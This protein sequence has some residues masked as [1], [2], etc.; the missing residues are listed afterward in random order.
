VESAEPFPGGAV[1]APDLSEHLGR[2]Q[3]FVSVYLH[4]DPDVENAGQL[5]EQRWKTLRSELEAMDA[6]PETLDR[7]EEQVPDAHARGRVLGVVA[8][9]S[10]ALHVEHGE[11]FRS[12][13]LGRIDPV[14]YVL[15][16]IR[17][18][19]TSPPILVVLIDRTGADVFAITRGVEESR[20]VAGEDGPVSKVSAGG[21]SMR[22]Y[23]ER[24]ENTWERNAENVAETLQAMARRFDPRRIAV[25]GDVRAAT[26]LREALA[27]E[28]Q[29]VVVEISGDRQRG[30]GGDPIPDGV[31]DLVTEIVASE[32]QALS[33]RLRQEL[34]EEDLGAE[35]MTD[36]V[37][38]LLRAQVDTLLIVDDAD[39]DTTLWVG[40]KPAE[41]ATS[42]EDLRAIGVEHPMQARARDAIVRAALATDA[43]IRILDAGTDL[44]QGV[45]GLLRWRNGDGTGS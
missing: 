11:P 5:A 8:D 29:G 36:V 34:G 42:A 32:T 40:E 33:E 2:S 4:T 41:L 25:A 19:Q 35:G 45:G 37:A 15:P 20:E 24:A 10:G 17:W 43:G 9:A 23:Q 12:Q 39:D 3:P 22:R 30:E 13:D 18:R 16:M 1:K 7:I 44:R 26:L 28:L 21:W 14:P 6:P 27:P 31:A 38:A